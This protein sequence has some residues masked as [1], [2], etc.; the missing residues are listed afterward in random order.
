[1]P[2]EHFEINYLLIQVNYINNILSTL[3]VFQLNITNVIFDVLPRP[4]LQHWMQLDASYN[5][6]LAR[7]SQS[8]EKAT[9][10]CLY[11]TL[12]CF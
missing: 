11:C 10:F 2:T 4:T 12:L 9:K 5:V 1:M 8:A 6:L 7:Q 3:T